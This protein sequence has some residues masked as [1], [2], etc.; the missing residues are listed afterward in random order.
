M[1]LSKCYADYV[2]KIPS[3][4]VWS[5]GSSGRV[6]KVLRSS[7]EITR[8]V[9]AQLRVYQACGMQAGHRILSLPGIPPYGSNQSTPDGLKNINVRSLHFS[10]PA[11]LQYLPIKEK[12]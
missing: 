6:K 4:E 2:E 11:F 5:S 12:G 8:I 9:A 3:V 7:D 1:V 10:I